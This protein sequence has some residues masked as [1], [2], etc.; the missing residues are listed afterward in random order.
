MV[1]QQVLAHHWEEVR[2]QLREKYD[3]LA[4]DDL[5]NFPGN[6][7]QLIGRIHQKTGISHEAIEA[8]LSTLT[9][10][11]KAAIAALFERSFTS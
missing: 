8:Y 3:Q 6:V 5:P 11:G 10:E 4:E 1:N 2:D 9:D 7:D